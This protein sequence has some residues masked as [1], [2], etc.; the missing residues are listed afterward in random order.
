MRVAAACRHAAL[1]L[2][3]TMKPIQTLREERGESRM[4]VAQALGI[5]LD[6]LTRFELGQDEPTVSQLRA[7]AEHFDVAEQD[8]DLDPRSGQPPSAAV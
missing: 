8:I 7:L 3:A 2:E 1:V 6:E 4:H 5:T